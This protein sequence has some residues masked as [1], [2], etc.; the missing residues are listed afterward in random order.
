MNAIQS[1][2]T[3]MTARLM[4]SNTPPTSPS[5]AAH[6]PPLS[7]QGKSLSLATIWPFHQE[8]NMTSPEHYS[9]KVG[10]SGRSLLNCSLVFDRQTSAYLDDQTKIFLRY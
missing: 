1:L 4:S 2:S 5:A 9:G 8:P 3:S 6:P 10:A 7:N